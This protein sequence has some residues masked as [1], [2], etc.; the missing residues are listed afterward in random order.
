[1]VIHKPPTM[2]G[3]KYHVRFWKSWKMC[4]NVVKPN[5]MTKMLA[6]SLDGLY[7]YRTYKLGSLSAGWYSVEDMAPLMSESR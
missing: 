6:A 3:V 7:R 1:V 2:S 5:V 4:A